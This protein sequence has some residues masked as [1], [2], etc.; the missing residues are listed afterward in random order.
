LTLVEVMRGIP[1]NAVVA[2]ASVNAKPLHDGLAVRV[3]H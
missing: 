3:V 1:E 2:L